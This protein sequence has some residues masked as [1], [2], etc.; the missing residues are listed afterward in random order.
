MN[1]IFL[2]TQREFTSRVRK[3]SF[4][5][6][7]I[8]APLLFGGFISLMAY[9]GSSKD[10]KIKTIAVIDSSSFFINKIQ[11]TQSLK[12]EFLINVKLDE[13]K[14][15]LKKSRY[16][17]ILYIKPNKIDSLKQVQFYSYSQPGISVVEHISN[18]MEKELRNQKLKTYNIENLDQIL[19]SVESDINL[20]TIKLSES[21]TEK[22]S[23]TIASMGVAYV[24]SLL[25]YMFILLYGVQVMRGVIEEKSNRIVEVIIS[26]VK[27][28]QL[29]MGKVLGVALTAI[30]QFLIW[31][32]L[33]VTI[34]ILAKQVFMP[35]INQASLGTAQTISQIQ[36]APSANADAIKVFSMIESIN[37]LKIAGL[38]LFYFIT[39]YLLYSSLFAAVGAAVDNEAD[40]QQF[41]MPITIPLIAGIMIMIQAFQYPD[42]PIAVWG[43]IIPFT[44]P[45][46]MM[47]RIPYEVPWEQLL[48]SMSLMV[49]TF[50]GT[51]W[52]AAK[53]YR[54]GILM[55]GKKITFKE[56]F[57]WLKYKN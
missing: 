32:V 50:I 56:L 25:I 1:K 14:K 15:D 28:F 42:S 16:Y 40:T 30:T 31:V 4:I 34:F 18:S 9:F 26:S 41:V 48:L 22:D 44:A 7:S 36:A 43:S 51:I 57:T 11:N 3:K 5:I 53:I 6:M 35:D 21:G 33:S 8:L 46:V 49:A 10:E 45:I 55:Y 23:N 19:K 13:L 2:I 24:G 12:F 27:P 47:A 54:T 39:G 20:Q 29:M 37:F 17:G 38:F 52:L